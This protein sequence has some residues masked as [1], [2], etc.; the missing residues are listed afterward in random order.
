[1]HLKYINYL[2]LA[3]EEE[4]DNAA[5][6]V[7]EGIRSFVHAAIQQ[8]GDPELLYISSYFIGSSTQDVIHLKK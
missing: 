1:M 2:N 8:F 7:M 6:C 3:K 4:E 5:T